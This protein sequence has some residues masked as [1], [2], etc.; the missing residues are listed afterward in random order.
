MKQARRHQFRAG[1]YLPSLAFDYF[2]GIDAN[3]FGIRGPEDRQNLG[4]VVQGTLNV[5]V[6]NWGATRSKVRQ[7]ELQ[8]RQAKSI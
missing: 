8:Q 3:V 4:S 6:W 2:Y 7:A 5:P 1:G